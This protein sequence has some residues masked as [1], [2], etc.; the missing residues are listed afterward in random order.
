V[1]WR[2]RGISQDPRRL[3]GS[4]EFMDLSRIAS[5]QSLTLHAGFSRITARFYPSPLLGYDQRSCHPSPAY[6]EQSSPLQLSASC[7]CATRSTRLFYSR[8]L[9][10]IGFDRIA[11]ARIVR[12]C[13]TRF[14]LEQAQKSVPGRVKLF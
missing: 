7:A 5:C 6:P 13:E 10:T 9:M 11:F 14:K 12:E 4:G 1:A 8:I 2:K 3:R